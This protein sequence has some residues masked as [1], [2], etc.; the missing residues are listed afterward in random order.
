MCLAHSGLSSIHSFNK[1]IQS[2]DYVPGTFLGTRATD[3][4]VQTGNA[5]YVLVFT[6]MRI[7]SLGR[8]NASHPQKSGLGHL[9]RLGQ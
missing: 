6:N 5:C 3:E 7:T 1:S 8:D 2:T 4:T 9:T